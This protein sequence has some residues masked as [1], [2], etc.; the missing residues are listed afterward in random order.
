MSGEDGSGIDRA[1]SIAEPAEEDGTCGSAEEPEDDGS[2]SGEMCGKDDF[3]GNVDVV[4]DGGRASTP[5]AD[6]LVANP[7]DFGR[8]VGERADDG[9]FLKDDTNDADGCNSGGVCGWFSFVSPFS[10]RFG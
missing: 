2:D 6:S 7:I 1:S 4:D 8:R 10:A 3:L 9:F 5:D